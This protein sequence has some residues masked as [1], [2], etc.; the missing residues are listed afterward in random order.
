MKQIKYFNTRIIRDNE[1]FLL[2]EDV[3][4]DLLCCESAGISFYIS[5]SE[6]IK[7]LNPNM[8]REIILIDGMA[9]FDY[10]QYITETE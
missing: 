5:Q 7:L 8:Y 4:I 2:V 9:D 10:N 6:V 3:G 1:V